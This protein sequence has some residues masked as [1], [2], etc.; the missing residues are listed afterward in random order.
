MTFTRFYQLRWQHVEQL[1]E[2]IELLYISSSG[3]TDQQ[4][5]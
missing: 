5:A 1:L 3:R 4:H 2:E